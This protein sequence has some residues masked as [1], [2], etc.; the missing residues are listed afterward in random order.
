MAA[1]GKNSAVAGGNADE[2]AQVEAQL[3]ARDKAAEDAK[4][5]PVY[6]PSEDVDKTVGEEFVEEY[7]DSD[8]NVQLGVDGKNPVSFFNPAP[9][10]LADP[11][12]VGTRD[13][14]AK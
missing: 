8:S 4:D 9:K 2:S 12:R 7:K 10:A 1:S 6:E 11:Y 3:E 14:D 5:N 13:E